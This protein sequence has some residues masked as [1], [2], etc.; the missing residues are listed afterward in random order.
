MKN[1]L[2]LT[3]VAALGVAVSGCKK[4]DPNPDCGCEGPT[5]K[6]IKN[7]RAVHEGG[8]LFS[9]EFTEPGT[10]RK[11]IAWACNADTTW[12]KSANREVPD[13]TIS[14]NLKKECFFGPTFIII[15]PPIEITAIRKD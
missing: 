8:G 10:Q 4:E 6:V 11:L 5:V 3:L 15:Y 13:Y 14:G 2:S 12:A 7:T 1:L 9:F